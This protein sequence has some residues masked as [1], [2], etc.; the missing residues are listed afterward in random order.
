MAV[1]AFDN[2][3]RPDEN[4]LSDEGNWS[5][6]TTGAIGPAQLVSHLV[7]GTTAGSYS[8]AA[9]AA[10]A[11]NDQWSETT[12][13]ASGAGT[14]VG[15]EA[16]ASLSADTE[17]VF[18]TST[19]S[20]GTAYLLSRVAGT[21]SVLSSGTVTPSVGDVFRIAVQGKVLKVYQNGTHLTAFDA[22]DSGIASGH[23]GLFIGQNNADLTVAQISYWRAGDFS[24]PNP[25]GILPTSGLQGATLNVMVSGTEFDA[26]GG[27]TLSLSGTGITVNSYSVQN[28]TTITANITISGSA[29]VGARDVIVTNA[30]D[31]QTGTLSGAFTVTALVVN[32]HRVRERTRTRS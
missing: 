12:L 23:F 17:Y 18:V 20:S 21:Q 14:Y 24:A 3:Q 28:A 8:L 32:T 9:W 25:T 7:E 2:F 15:P 5:T 10:S 11:P 1:L 4:P 22:T 16:R 31:G 29:A 6:E 26:D 27:A 13:H 19:L 30:S